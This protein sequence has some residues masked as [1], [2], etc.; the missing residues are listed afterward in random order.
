[1]CDGRPSGMPAH[2]HLGV[3]Y[4]WVVRE[5]KGKRAI[6][7]ELRRLQPTGEWGAWT[8]DPLGLA[9]GRGIDVERRGTE[10]PPTLWD[11]LLRRQRLYWESRWRKQQHW[12]VVDSVEVDADDAEVLSAADRIL[13]RLRLLG[14]YPL[15][16][17]LLDQTSP[18][19]SR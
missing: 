11:R 10:I 15:S 16:K 14:V 1:M 12:E 2:L 3:G 18:E 5:T 6:T 4:D 7:V 17:P 8:Y 13:T 9:G 19:S